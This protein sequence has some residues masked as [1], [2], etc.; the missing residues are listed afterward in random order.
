MTEVICVINGFFP[1]E[2][3]LMGYSMVVILT[4][5]SF[6]AENIKK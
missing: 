2:G 4:K 5:G 6:Y 1:V 3:M